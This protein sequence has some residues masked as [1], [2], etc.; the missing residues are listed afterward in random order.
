VQGLAH[1]LAEESRTAREEDPLV[2][3][4]CHPGSVLVSGAPRGLAVVTD[5]RP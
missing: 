1:R 4:C 2:F 3:E 5:S